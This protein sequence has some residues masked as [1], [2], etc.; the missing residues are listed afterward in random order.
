MNDKTACC[1]RDAGCDETLIGAIA[2]APSGC[3]R[4]QLLKEHR[5]KLLGD[6]H[7]GQ[8]RLECL[9]YLIYRLQNDDDDI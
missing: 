7:A 6:I 5:R 9:D 3:A 8:K 4:M 1:L 2:D